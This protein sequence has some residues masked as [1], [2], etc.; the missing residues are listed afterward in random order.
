[1]MQDTKMRRLYL[2]EPSALIATVTNNISIKP[3]TLSS[4]QKN[5]TLISKLLKKTLQICR[6]FSWKEKDESEMFLYFSKQRSTSSRE[7][8]SNMYYVCQHDGHSK[9]HRRKEEDR[10]RNERYHHGRIKRD[11]FCPARMNVKLHK[12][13]TTVSVTYIGAHNHPL[14]VENTVHQPTPT[15]GL[16]SIKTKL[17]LGVPVNNIYCELRQGVG[18]RNSH[19][20]SSEVISKKHLQKKS[21]VSD[22][23]RHMNYGRRL[24]PDDS[25]STYLL[26]K[27]LQEEDFNIVLVYKYPR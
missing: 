3:N 18:N 15:S 21:N 12:S 11:T 17:S 9:A 10:K 26:V 5:I 14:G 22:I 16:I 1:M 2:R 25:T 24:H 20:T 23:H 19:E 4:F 8:A 7:I 13:D 6:S 27:K